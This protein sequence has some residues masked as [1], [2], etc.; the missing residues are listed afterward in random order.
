MGSFLPRSFWLYLSTQSQASSRFY[1]FSPATGYSAARPCHGEVQLGE[2]IAGDPGVGKG[3]SQAAFLLQPWFSSMMHYLRPVRSPS[4]S[5]E[6]QGFDPFVH[7]HHTFVLPQD[8]VNP[9]CP[10]SDEWSEGCYCPSR[11][12]KDFPILQRLWFLQRHRWGENDAL[13]VGAE[14]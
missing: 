7:Q 4:S 10:S 2:G 11:A 13:S 3:F 9:G 14:V 8:G 5:L 1:F 6:T 12:R